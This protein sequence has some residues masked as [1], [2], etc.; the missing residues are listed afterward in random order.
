M[1]WILIAL[2]G[3]AGAS[4]R[5]ALANWTQ[6]TTKANVFPVGILVVNLLGCFAIGFIGQLLQNHPN[7]ERLKLFFLVGVLGALTTFS[8]YALDTL[9]LLQLHA[10]NVA[11]ANVVLNNS[12][13]I[14][15]V[16][17]GYAAASM[18][19]KGVTP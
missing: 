3:A 8:S 18:L 14:A 17:L 15:L 19:Q 2:G 16:F 10:W 6:H 12:L 7:P 5:Y 13:G 11:I 9:R 1:K 4:L